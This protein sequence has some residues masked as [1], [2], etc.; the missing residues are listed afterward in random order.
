MKNALLLLGATVIT[1]TSVYHLTRN[2]AEPIESTPAE[3]NTRCVDE[4]V[5]VLRITNVTYT[6]KAPKLGEKFSLTV[7]ADIQYNADFGY[8][9]V[10]IF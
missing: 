7:D 5:K 4:P 2:S 8:V 3:W 1:L 10:N 9:H 6:D